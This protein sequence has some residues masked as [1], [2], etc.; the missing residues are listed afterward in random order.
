MG[1]IIATTGSD[2]MSGDHVNVTSDYEGTAMLA[3]LYN[4]I[5][6]PG[7]N[8]WNPVDGSL[9]YW[10]LAAP[11]EP[12]GWIPFVK[13]REVQKNY[14]RQTTGPIPLEENKFELE[15]ELISGASPIEKTDALAIAKPLRPKLKD[16][17]VSNVIGLPAGWY[18]IAYGYIVSG[19]V[20]PEDGGSGR[21]TG[22]GP[23]SDAFEIAQ[24]QGLMVTAPTDIPEEV[25]KVIYY[26]TKPQNSEVKALTAPLYEQKA[27]SAKGHPKVFL[28][29]GPL[30]TRKKWNLKNTSFVG[31]DDEGLTSGMDVEDDRNQFGAGENQV[32]SDD[33]NMAYRFVGENGGQS[34]SAELQ[35]IGKLDGKTKKRVRPKVFPE[36]TVGWV[37]ELVAT[38][39]ESGQDREFT[40]QKIKPRAN[41]GERPDR[42]DRKDKRIGTQGGGDSFFKKDEWAEVYGSNEEDYP[43][44]SGEKLQRESDEEEGGGGGSF[45]GSSSFD[46]TTGVEAPTDSPEI[47]EIL[48]LNTSG[49]TPGR[50][51]VKTALFVGDSEGPASEAKD[52]VIQMGEGIRITRPMWHN[53]MYNSD[54]GEKKKDKPKEP[55]EWDFFEVESGAKMYAEKRNVIELADIA[56][57]ATDADFFVTAPVELEPEFGRY[58]VNM[59]FRFREH[60]RGGVD[61]W[62]D[63]YD[64]A[65]TLLQSQKVEHI[66][67]NNRRKK[68]VR[69]H[70]KCS[71]RNEDIGAPLVTKLHLDTVTLRMRV[72][73]RGTGRGGMRNFKPSFSDFSAHSGWAVPDLLDINLKAAQKSI[74][75]PE[76]AITD[77][78][79][80]DFTVDEDKKDEDEHD[81]FEVPHGGYCIVK[82]DPD[83][84]PKITNFSTRDFTIFETGTSEDWIHNVSDFNAMIND[85]RE[86]AAIHS[87]YGLYMAKENDAETDDETNYVNKP[88]TPDT[89]ISITWDLYVDSFSQ[90]DMDLGV[91][92]NSDGDAIAWMKL[93]ADGDVTIQY[94]LANG[95]WS[96]PTTVVT[97]LDNG[98]MLHWEMELDIDAGNIVVYFG[99]DEQDREEM[100][101]L[102]GLDLDHFINA[103]NVIIGPSV[104]GVNRFARFK[105]M[106]GSIKVTNIATYGNMF[107]M[108]GNYIEYYGPA[109]TPLSTAYGPRGLRVPC[110]PNMPYT[111]GV[112]VW[113]HQVFKSVVEGDNAKKKKRRRRKKPN[114]PDEPPETQGGA[115]VLVIR[116][117]DE[118]HNTLRVYDPIAKIE[119]T[120]RR[121]TRHTKTIN[122]PPGTAYLEF[123]ENK[124]GQGTVKLHGLQ[125][126]EGTV[127][128]PFNM[129]RQRDGWFSVFF[130]TKQEG[131]FPDDPFFEASRLKGLRDVFVAATDDYWTSYKLSY[132]SANTFAELDAKPYEID[133]GELNHEH[134]IIEVRV[135]MNSALDDLTP[136]VRYIELDVKRRDS[137]LLRANGTEYLGGTVAFEISTPSAPPHWENV[138]L[139]DGSRVA[140]EWGTQR[141]TTIKFKVSAFRK[142]TVAEI[143]RNRV[144]I[145]ET[146]DYRY[147]ISLEEPPEFE[148]EATSRVYFPDGREFFQR[149]TADITAWVISEERLK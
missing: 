61:V 43:E 29:K 107:N 16:Y 14:A 115:H 1:L 132:K 66:G 146:P 72:R 2:L 32:S 25:R 56:D 91:I 136:E 57:H 44:E 123:Y 98:M 8:K 19:N 85:I 46:D 144:H 49:L 124:L 65:G 52:I 51:H 76:P 100:V 78:D 15:D 33:I 67:R 55:E 58:T 142:S 81:R 94:V 37:P 131:M 4:L 6:D 147:R 112:N 128:H 86:N 13:D 87:E 134:N 20:H 143:L 45:G 83:D 69:R 17:M 35:N 18:C 26:L 121:W 97:G 149:E 129:R 108:K 117:M 103:A 92:K 74:N 60:M 135:D 70:Y 79:D 40:I 36:G 73:G 42:R 77:I 62:I 122:T 102:E 63:E 75:T 113:H 118:N 138:D 31:D 59:S 7:W 116:A 89:K 48:D 53:K 95:S 127:A 12:D 28:M 9:Y 64:D 114:D 145:L 22:A 88:F 84:G 30:R 119:G 41:K 5:P 110:K 126:E 47:P 90:H 140:S 39:V 38:D 99:M 111:F 96:A 54:M 23:R 130:S 141:I 11:P 10:D 80:P 3:P 125:M 68:P 21:K 50:H 109:G 82:V 34:Q 148:T 93:Q 137:Q 71:K 27:Y 139:A 104:E 133:Y 120:P 24:G 101:R 105:L 106:F